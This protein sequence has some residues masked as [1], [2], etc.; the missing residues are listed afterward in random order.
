MS[1]VLDMWAGMTG[2]VL[3]FAGTAAPNGWLMCYGQAVSRAN[4]PNL[5]AAIGTTFG[6]GDGAT[7]FNLPDT[8][9]RA[10]IGKDDMGGAAANRITP[11]GSGIA[12]N[13]P[14][15]AGGNETHTLTAAQMPTHTHPNTVTDPGHTHANTVTNNPHSHANTLSDPG[16]THGHNANSANSSS[17]TGGGGFALPATS[18]ATISAAT[19]GI[20]INNASA[21]SAVTISNASQTA[22]VTI[23][24]ASQGSGGAHPNVQ[25]GIVFNKIIKA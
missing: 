5:F 25:P 6:A 9:G 7:T 23:T 8:R 19:T 13:V 15:S 3:D 4:Y 24:N 12:G 10:A 22:G 21:A 16:H 1:R 2:T 11:T 20:T 17:S 18:G 14:G